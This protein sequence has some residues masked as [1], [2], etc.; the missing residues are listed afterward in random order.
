MFNLCKYHYIYRNFYRI[1]IKKIKK[2]SLI[3]ILNSFSYLSVEEERMIEKL[4][5]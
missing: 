3:Y 4:L 1:N 2:K 5:C